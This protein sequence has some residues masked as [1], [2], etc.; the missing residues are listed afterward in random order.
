MYIT[1][2]VSQHYLIKN[3]INYC[4]Y[5]YILRVKDVQL[6]QQSKQQIE[7]FLISY[8]EYRVLI[9]N[10]YLCAVT[11]SLGRIWTSIEAR[12]IKFSRARVSLLQAR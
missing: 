3:N 1:K 9:I 8:R 6:T 10:K 7:L 5:M 12:E 2:V 4:P 11:H